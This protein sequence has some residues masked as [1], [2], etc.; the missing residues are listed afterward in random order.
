MKKL[1]TLW[2]Y[3]LLLASVLVYTTAGMS[4]I[5]VCGERRCQFCRRGSL[6]TDIYFQ[7]CCSNIK[8]TVNFNATCSTSSCVFFIFYLDIFLDESSMK[9]TPNSQQSSHYPGWHTR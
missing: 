9:H 5:S 4:R 1:S 7:S 3:F 6:D 2:I 8:Y